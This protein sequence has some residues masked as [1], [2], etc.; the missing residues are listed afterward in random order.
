M[1]AGCCIRCVSKIPGNQKLVRFCS[2][3]RARR[4]HW[5]QKAL[6]V[7]CLVG[8]RSSP[9]RLRS[10]V[11]NLIQ[12]KSKLRSP[13]GARFPH[14]W[15]ACVGNSPTNQ[16]IISYMKRQLNIANLR[17]CATVWPIKPEMNAIN[18]IKVFSTKWR[19]LGQSSQ[20]RLRMKTNASRLRVSQPLLAHR[21]PQP[22]LRHMYRRCLDLIIF[23]SDRYFQARFG[24][25][26][27][28][29]QAY[30]VTLLQR[31]KAIAVP[32]D[33][34]EDRHPSTRHCPP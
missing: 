26:A 32:G 18:A 14:A 1:F 28:D 19:L 5:G 24:E 2:V 15:R 9:P 11:G 16:Q 33:C 27:F 30:P 25:T 21:Q 31:K 22:D 7:F 8:L 17:G 13:P 10:T 6:W 12:L 29:M 23:G 34:S 4:N 20:T 3:V